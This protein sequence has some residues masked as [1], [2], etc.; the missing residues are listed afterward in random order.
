MPDLE[1]TPL[2]F[3]V[4]ADLPAEQAARVIHGNSISIAFVQERL[5]EL[6]ARAAAVSR[7]FGSDK[8]DAV[9]TGRANGQLDVI[10][11]LLRPGL[12]LELPLDRHI[13]AQQKK[14]H[15]A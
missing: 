12:G 4:P 9:A 10:E 8:S 5:R 15:H 14:G 11:L 2:S 6:Q 3:S 13:A 1:N 7:A